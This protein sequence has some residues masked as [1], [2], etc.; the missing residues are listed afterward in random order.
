MSSTAPQP[1][2]L[3]HGMGTALEAPT[4]PTITRI[5]AEEVLG[6]FPE[7]G[8]LV[9]LRWHSPRPFS[10]ATLAQ[11]SGGEFFLKRHHRRLRTVAALKEEHD[12][13]A[14]LRSA[15]SSVPDVVSTTQGASAIEQGDWSYEL[16]R[17]APGMDIYR[18]RQS[19]TPFL[20]YEHAYEAGV[21]LAQ[22][23]LAARGFDAAPRGAHPLVASF[24]IL[25]ARDPVAAAEDYVSARPALAAFLAEVPWRQELTRLFGSLGSGL[26]ER[27]E[28][29]LPLWTHNDWHPS[30]LL[31]SMDGAVSAVFDFGLAIRS[32]ALHDLA[33]AIERTA[34]PWLGLANGMIDKG[35]DVKAA[36]AILAGYRTVQI[37]TR[38]EIEVIVQLL[39]LVHVEFAL[40][41]IDYFSGILGDQDQ[42][43]LAWKAYLIDHADWFLSPSGQ[44][45]LR[46]VAIGASR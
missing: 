25:P 11:T 40:S 28:E 6:H 22:L 4:W 17:I 15:G 36:L 31:W 8:Q 34:I 30:N 45:F 5:E 39:P 44:D 10:A 42:A 35:G 26:S 33:T 13:I 37:L 46:Q 1:G 29:Q 12:F 23:H 41:E 27:L 38:A 24:T 9:K 14:H 32:C 19:W 43:T 3:V 20:S 21:A 18:D 2:H 7:A 16:H